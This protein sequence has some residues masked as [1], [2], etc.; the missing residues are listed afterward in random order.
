MKVRT[1]LARSKHSQWWL[2]NKV[3]IAAQAQLFFTSVCLQIPKDM[4][5]LESIISMIDTWS[6]AYSCLVVVVGVVQ[7]FVLK[8][9][10]K[11]TPTTSKLR[12]RI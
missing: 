5:R 1:N 9:F 2:G 8:R 3:T 7:L 11:E 4:A 6:M 12:M 10:F